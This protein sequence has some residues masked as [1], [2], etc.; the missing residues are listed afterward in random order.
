[1]L[2]NAAGIGQGGCMVYL[3]AAR[4]ARA[5]GSVLQVSNIISTG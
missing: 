3:D 1:M 5:A 2:G 4:E